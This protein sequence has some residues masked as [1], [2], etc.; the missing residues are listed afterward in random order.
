[1][2]AADA[3]AV[4]L[5]PAHQYPT[6]GPLHPERRA[7]VID[8]AHATDGLVIE[9]DYDGEFRYDR[10]PV[11]AVQGLDPAHVVYVGSVS[12]SLS[13][14]VRLGW[15]V[16]PDALVDAVLAAKRER[17]LSVSVPDQL[18]LADLIESGAYYRHVRRM[19]QRY[20][21]RRDQLVS[22]LAERAPHIAVTGI[23]AG[24]HA[25]LELRP[26]TEPHHRAGRGVAGPGR[27]RP[28]PLP[29]PGGADAAPGRP[30]GG[31]RHATGTHVRGRPGRAVPGPGT[32]G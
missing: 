9:D 3:R 31:V 17:E 14:A 21:R 30:G 11:G 12:K 22:L 13:P 5:T 23:A 28:E 20:R 2:A 24:L 18:L 7:A 25:V 29:P 10:Q 15:L 16:L 32:P 27:G 8:W 26:G 19:R 1:M 4:L 6:G